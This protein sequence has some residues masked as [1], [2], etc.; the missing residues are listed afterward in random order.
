[1]VTCTRDDKGKLIAVSGEA[2]IPPHLLTI[3]IPPA[4]TDVLVSTN[5]A[6]KLLASGLD[7]KLRRQPLYNP[8]YRA[9]QDAAKFEHVAAL[10]PLADSILAH[11]EQ[12]ARSGNECAIVA[13]L[14]YETGI[15]PGSLADTG[16]DV[17]AYGATTLLSSHVHYELN[18]VWLDFVGKKGVRNVLQ[19]S[20]P[21]LQDVLVR[22]SGRLIHCNGY[23]FSIDEK[24]L[25]AY[26][27]TLARGLR[28]KDLRTLKGTATAI[29]A[30]SALPAP[31][32]K[33]A[34]RKLV[35]SVKKTV[36]ATLGNTPAVAGRS[37]IA[38]SV[39]QP[40]LAAFAN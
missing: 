23:L 15:R 3:H 30:I 33:T 31:A 27:A 22:R 16:G 17:Q 26:V 34:A 18:R 13:L 29:Q 25:R 35:A 11:L 40:V 24:C 4:W 9:A 36:A 20:H 37:Y 32:T 5:P 7:S 39:L 14:V 2:S 10:T 6:A 1:M 38:P 21:L 8:A 19:V 12:D 28:P